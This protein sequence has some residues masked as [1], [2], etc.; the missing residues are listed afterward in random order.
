MFYEITLIKIISFSK[1]IYFFNFD[2]KLFLLIVTIMIF[3][4]K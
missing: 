2:Q 4:F 3:Y 1:F